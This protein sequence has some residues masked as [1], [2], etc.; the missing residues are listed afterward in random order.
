MKLTDDTGREL[1]AEFEVELTGDGA[2]IVMHARFGGPASPRRQ[3]VDYFEALELLLARLANIRASIRSVA[4]DSKVAQK[5]SLAE[6]LLDLGYPIHLSPATDARRLRLTMT[7]AQRTVARA[8]DAL[9]GGGNNHKR[10]R[11]ALDLTDQMTL[12]AL[13]E[14]LGASTSIPSVLGVDY[15]RAAA[16][17]SVTPAAVFTFDPAARERALAGHA[18]V[19][20]ADHVRS[21]GWLPRSPA[22]GEP[23]FDLAWVSACVHVAEVKSLTGANED[24]Q[25]RLGLGQVLHYRHQ[26][27]SMYGAARAVLA[28]EL[29]PGTE[30]IQLCESLGVA[31]VWLGTWDAL[32]GATDRLPKVG[33]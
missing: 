28:V 22:A 32:G 6:R 16:D 11:L 27:A 23:D 26:M 2:E 1:D 20:N 13:E 33:G 10:V 5:L 8:A 21:R 4:V 25:M 29:Q 7:R 3:N 12:P 9:P 19:Q 15:R 17:P 30:W 14:A 18:A 24:R 31:L